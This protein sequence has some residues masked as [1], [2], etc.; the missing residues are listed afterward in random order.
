MQTKGERGLE[1]VVKRQF[2]IQYFNGNP[3]QREGG[4]GR[5]GSITLQCKQKEREAWKERL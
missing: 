5:L 3:K 4:K 1:K 2:H